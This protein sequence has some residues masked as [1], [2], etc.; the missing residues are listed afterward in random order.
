MDMLGNTAH[1]FNL[2]Y[3]G[4]LGAGTLEARIYR[5]KVDHF[6]DFGSDKQ[7]LYTAGNTTQGMPM[8][9]TGTTTGASAKFNIDVTPQDMLRAG[10]EY[11]RY[12]LDDDWPAVVGSAGMGPND[13]IN[14]SNGKRDRTTL[15]GEWEQRLNAQWLTLAGLRYERVQTGADPVHGYNLATAP[16]TGAGGMMNQ[17]RDA[18]AFNSANRSRTDNNWDI[19]ALARYAV[20]AHSDYEAGFARKVRSPNLYERY[21][22]STANMMSI[23]NNYVGD[24]NGYIGNADL[25]PEVAHTLSLTGD[26]HSVDRTYELKATPYYTRVTDYIDAVQWNGATPAA[27]TALLTQ[28]F[29]TLKYV[30]QSARLYGADIS[31]HMPLGKSELGEWGLKGLVNYSK[32]KN[33]DTGYGLYNIMPL[34]A[35]LTLTQKTGAWDNA[36]EVVG[37]REKNDLSVERNEIR[38]PGYALVNLRASYSWQQARVDFGVENLFDRLYALPLGGAYTGQGTTMSIN[39]GAANMP[40]GVAVA[41]PGRSL[42]TALNFKF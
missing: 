16:L 22:W 13:F 41:G 28:Q 31:G 8:R 32:G 3:L 12:R 15:F 40:W 4:Q 29:V 36:L 19:T 24:G 20:D 10:A 1:R 21:S 34:N 11:Q 18:V 2:R 37:V 42:Y 39:P 26:W 17:T 25:K 35:K 30:N 5:E 23:M 9:T 33:L 38:T 6:M 7:F 14:I 27:R